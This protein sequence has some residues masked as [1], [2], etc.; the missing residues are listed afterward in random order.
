MAVHG[1]VGGQTSSEEEA[2][3]Q[4]CRVVP[5]C[6]ASQLCCR[7]CRR[8]TS[9]QEPESDEEK[10]GAGPIHFAK[11]E[12]WQR[13]RALKNLFAPGSP[14]KEPGESGGGGGGVGGSPETAEQP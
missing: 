4:R 3:V 10:E 7:S 8:R 14:E 9:L 6:V 13:E 12:S 11:Q 2:E 1:G 5:Q